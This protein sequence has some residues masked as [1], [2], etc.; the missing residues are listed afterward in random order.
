MLMSL[1]RSITMSAFLPGVSVPILPVHPNAR[2]PLMVAHSAPRAIAPAC[3]LNG[4][5][6]RSALLRTSLPRTNSSA[7]CIS[8]NI[9]PVRKGSTSM[10]SDGSAAGRA[11]AAT[12][13]S[14]MW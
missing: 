7:A 3:C 2:A 14:P 12:M 1:A 5:L 6:P 11:H 9:C 13:V 4:E 8:R 10:P